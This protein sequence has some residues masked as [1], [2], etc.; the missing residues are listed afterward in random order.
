MTIAATAAILSSSSRSTSPAQ[1]LS[2]R[3]DVRAREITV[4][5]PPPYGKITGYHL[6]IVYVDPARRQFVCE[7][8]PFDPATGSIPPAGATLFYGLSGLLTQGYCGTLLQRATVQQQQEQQ[9]FVTVLYG[10]EAEKAYRCF[11]KETGRFNAERIPYRMA[12]GPNSNSF[13]RMM[14]DRC[15]VP[16]IKPP[17]AVPVPGWEISLSRQAA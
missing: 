6:Y 5:M 9:H 11:E 3:I 14:L 1:D 13:V 8:F 12:T 7:G 17:A 15:D 10:G 16:A 2:E 4:N